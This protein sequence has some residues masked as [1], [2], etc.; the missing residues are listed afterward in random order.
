MPE[1]PEVETVRRILNDVIVGATIKTVDVRF[2]KIIQGDVDIFCQTLTGATFLNVE[3]IGKYLIFFLT[4]DIVLVSHLRMEG[5]YVEKFSEDEISKH[6]HVN[7]FLSDG[8]I[9]SY[10]DTRKFGT[11]E[12][13][14][15]NN[16]LSLPSLAKL[17]PEPFKMTADNLY[18]TLQ[19]KRIAL[20]ASLL[21]QTIM[22]GLGNIYADEVLFLT[23]LHPHLAS[24]LVKK[25]DAENIIK[26]SREVLNKA[27]KAGG[28]TVRSYAPASGISGSFQLNLFA[29]GRAGEKCLVCQRIMKRTVV[30]GRGTTYC[31]YCQKHDSIPTVIG[32]TGLIGAG[33]ST[34]GNMLKNEGYTVIDSDNI[35][36]ELYADKAVITALSRE[37]AVNLLENGVFSRELLRSFVR[38]NKDAAK[39]LNNFIHPLVKQKMETLIKSAQGVIVFEVPLIFSHQINILFDYIIGVETSV[40]KQLEYLSKRKVKPVLTPDATYFKNRAKLDY[41][42]INDED[43]ASLLSKFK[44]FKF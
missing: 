1:L 5:K 23:K 12:I 29:Y 28:T 14:T 27:I 38:E 35:V 22:T 32:I 16:Y 34:L 21:D 20:K 18:Q 33:K 37:L 6:G 2:R 42:I 9:L 17:G 7:F 26:V 4:N 41:I 13:A 19:T 31:P 10:E 30:A 25:K 11:M 44:A 40:E 43:E 3:R 39:K 36:K 15:K 24:N 8:R